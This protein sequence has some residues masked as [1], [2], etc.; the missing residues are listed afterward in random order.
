[1]ETHDSNRTQTGQRQTAGESTKRGRKSLPENALGINMPFFLGCLSSQSNSLLNIKV[2]FQIWSILVLHCLLTSGS[3]AVNGCHQNESSNSL[4]KHHNYPQV[5]HM[6]PV[7][8]LTSCEAKS[9]LFVINKSIIKMFLFSSPLSII[10]PSPMKTPSCLNHERNMHR[11]ME[12][13]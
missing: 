8:Q 9:C 1:M 6:T 4:W 12:I 5:I 2:R 13:V 11:P 7:H 10:L 3:S